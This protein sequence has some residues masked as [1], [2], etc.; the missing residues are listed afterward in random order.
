MRL[1]SYYDLDSPS[2]NL[3]D[4][5]VDIKG[6]R[7][8]FDFDLEGYTYAVKLRRSRGNQ[9]IGEAVCR[10][11]NEV[12]E[13]GCRVF[14]DRHGGTSLVIVGHTWRAPGAQNCSWMVELDLEDVA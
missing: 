11:G 7:I 4:A 9:F 5:V 3:R 2:W 8:A 13:L 12:A 10:P 1:G 14:E 6:G